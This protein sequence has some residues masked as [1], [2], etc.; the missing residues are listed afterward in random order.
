MNDTNLSFL[1]WVSVPAV[2]ILRSHHRLYFVVVTSFALG[3]ESQHR[4]EVKTRCAH[5]SELRNRRTQTNFYSM[6]GSKTWLKP[7]QRRIINCRCWRNFLFTFPLPKTMFEHSSGNR[8][9][10]QL[11]LAVRK[12]GGWDLWWEKTSSYV[13]KQQQAKNSK[14][15][16]NWR[17]GF[18]LL[19]PLPRSEKFPQKWTLEHVKN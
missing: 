14:N 16:P 9:H 7:I 6:R 8:C 17:N 19:F 3:E 15:F 18:V 4:R 12:K 10:R 2:L 11:L 1:S 5:A 13:G